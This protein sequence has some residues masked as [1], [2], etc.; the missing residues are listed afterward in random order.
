MKPSSF[1]RDYIMGN[2]R[3][4]EHTVPIKMSFVDLTHTG[5]SVSKNTFPY[6]PAVVAA[7]AKK[8]LEEEIDL[9]IFRFPEEFSGYLEKNIPKFACFSV[10]LR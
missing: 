7:Y 4:E 1:E 9:E 6:G 8:Q 10:F 2:Y 5:V 3:N